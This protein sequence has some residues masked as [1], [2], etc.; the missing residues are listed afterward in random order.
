[1]EQSYAQVTKRRRTRGFI[2]ES[3]QSIAE[4]ELGHRFSSEELD[5]LSQRFSLDNFFNSCE[6][7][8]TIFD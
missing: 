6:K 2:S 5:T 1:M 3:I 8:K 4:H 7:V